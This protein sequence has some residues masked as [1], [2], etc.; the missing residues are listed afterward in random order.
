MLGLIWR[1]VSFGSFHAASEDCY[2]VS[3]TEQDNKSALNSITI[4]ANQ[5]PLQGDSEG[6]C[7]TCSVV[8]IT[9]FGMPPFKTALS[10]GAVVEAGPSEEDK[11]LV[12]LLPQRE[13]DL[14][15]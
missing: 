9:I 10:V 7:V 2:L 1:N 11:P 13:R 6:A 3:A 5:I 4:Q 15:S 8:A 14:Y 12:F